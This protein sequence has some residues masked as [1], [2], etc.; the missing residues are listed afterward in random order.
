MGRRNCTL[1]LSMISKYGRKS[2][3]KAVNISKSYSGVH[4]LQDASFELRAGEVHA[5][6]GE[7]GA[8]KSTLIKIITGAVIPTDGEIVLDGER[9]ATIRQHLEVARHRGDLSAAGA[10]SGVDGR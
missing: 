4:A 6:V 2:L 5:L 8:G 9:H 3:L 1:S 7:N 10:F